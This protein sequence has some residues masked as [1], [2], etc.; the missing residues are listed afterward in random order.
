MIRYQ[1]DIRTFGNTSRVLYGFPHAG[2]ILPVKM[3]K[4]TELFLSV[5]IQNNPSLLDQIA[6]SGRRWLVCHF[7][8]N[9]TQFPH[10]NIGLGGATVSE[11]DE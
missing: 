2:T 7:V 9:A 3:D 6:D 8:S 11:Y 10:Q 5:A 1:I 4:F